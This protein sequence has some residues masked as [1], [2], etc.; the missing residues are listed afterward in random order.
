VTPELVR[1]DGPDLEVVLTTKWSEDR[2]E[3]AVRAPLHSKAKRAAASV[4][5]GTYRTSR[6]LDPSG[7]PQLVAVG[8]LDGVSGFGTFLMGGGTSYA[9]LRSTSGLAGISDAGRATFMKAVTPE[10]VVQARADGFAQV[11]T[12]VGPIGVLVNC[13]AP[14]DYLTLASYDARTAGTIGIVI[15]L[16]RAPVRD[17]AIVDPDSF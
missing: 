1:V 15:D 13:G 10:L 7:R 8:A 5:V 6:Y 12:T 3:L 16:R 2:G 17:G 14:G 4:P 11:V 9:Y